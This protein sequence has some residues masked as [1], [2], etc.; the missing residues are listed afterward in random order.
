MFIFQGPDCSVTGGKAQAFLHQL[1]SN[2]F[3]LLRQLYR[4][5]PGL[6]YAPISLTQMTFTAGTV[7]LLGAVNYQSKRSEKRFRTALAGANEC[8]RALQEMGQTWQCATQTG[9]VLGNMIQNWCPQGT[10]EDVRTVGSTSTLSSP[11]VNTPTP[12]PIE[13]ET[14]WQYLLNDPSSDLIKELIKSGWL[15]PTS[16]VDPK[17]AHAPA[18]STSVRHFC[19]MNRLTQSSCPAYLP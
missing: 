16:R 4:K 10:Q 14:N 11:A 15:P 13:T 17:P 12:A 9:H 5:M 6:R 8:V 2:A 7:H 18:N 19:L 3:G 1:L